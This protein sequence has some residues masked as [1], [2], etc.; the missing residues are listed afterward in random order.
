MLW[1]V[2]NAALLRQFVNA[3]QAHARLPAIEQQ[4]ALDF[5]GQLE[6]DYVPALAATTVRNHA[7]N[8]G[9]AAM[10]YET[11][12]PRS[13]PREAIRPAWRAA[14]LAYR[15]NMRVTRHNS[16]AWHAAYAAFRELLPDMPEGQAKHETTHAIAYAAANHTVWFWRGVYGSSAE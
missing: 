5:R 13:L 3:R 7:K 12:A 4:Q 16:P 10:T 2:T 11:S 8:I 6:L 14:V 1:V 15:A 9:D